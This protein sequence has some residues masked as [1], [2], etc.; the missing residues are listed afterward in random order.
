MGGYCL[1]CCYALCVARCGDMPILLPYMMFGTR[2]V[3]VALYRSAAVSMP[4]LWGSCCAYVVSGAEQL[5]LSAAAS[6][7]CW[8]LPG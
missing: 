1:I 8:Q 4:G 2:T 3:L 6:P 5:L 7:T